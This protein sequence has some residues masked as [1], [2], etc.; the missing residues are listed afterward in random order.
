[1]SVKFYPII[2][3]TYKLK[4]YSEIS[5][6]SVQLPG[7]KMM[8]AERLYPKIKPLINPVI[9]LLQFKVMKTT[10]YLVT[11]PDFIQKNYL[12]YRSPISLKYYSNS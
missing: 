11:V 7:K 5:F 1:M 3:R 10:H 2:V 12:I 6:H 4:S 8:Y 9:T